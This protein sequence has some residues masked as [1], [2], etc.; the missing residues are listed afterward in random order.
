MFRVHIPR[1]THIK[2]NG[3]QCGSPALRG[4][5]YCYFHKNWR[6]QRVRPNAKPTGHASITLPVLEDADSIQVALMQVLRVILAGQ[7]D[8]KTAGLLLYGLQTAS[9]NLR[10]MQLEPIKKERIVVNPGW[11]RETGVGDD[12]WCEEDFDE[13]EA[14]DEDNDEEDVAPDESCE[15][16]VDAEDTVDAEADRPKRHV[17]VARA[18]S[19]RHGARKR[20]RTRCTDPYAGDDDDYDDEDD[21]QAIARCLLER[22]HLPVGEPEKKP[23]MPET[24]QKSAVPEKGDTKKVSS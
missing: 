7:I 23:P 13:E 18:T 11:V 16:A 24:Q 22:L 10:S 20:A 4:R 14:S 6:E 19:S 9:L 17:R 5:R 1:C 21:N 8:S 12:A 3:T 15:D 2:T